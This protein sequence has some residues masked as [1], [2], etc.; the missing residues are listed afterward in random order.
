MPS[1][2]PLTPNPQP[3][4][5]DY[6]SAFKFEIVV[7][8][9]STG[10]RLGLLHT[11]HGTIETP[12]FMPV[13]TAGTVK[14][15]TQS[16][17]EWLGVQAIL[18]NTYHLYLRP[19]Q[20]LI[21]A[22]GGLHQFMSWPHPI[23]TDSGGFQVMSLKA[24]QRITEDGVEFRS[25]IDGSRH[26]FSPEKA[27]EVQL[28]FG[29]DILMI[30]DE[31]VSYPSSH[32][33]TRR[34]VKLTGRWA[35]RARKIYATSAEQVEQPGARALYGIVQGGVD[36]SLRRESA[37]EMREIGFEG[38]A[39][40]G[41]SVGEPKSLT[42]DL[43]EAVANHLPE[44]APRYLMG[45]GTPRDLAEGVARGID[46][47]DCVMPTRNARNACVFTSEGRLVIKAARYAR[48]QGPLD[49]A[50]RCAVCRR[51][52]R[53]YIRHLFVS[54]E[55]LAAILSTCHNLYFYLDTMNKIRQAIRAGSLR[56]FLSTLEG[57]I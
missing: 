26:F 29:S 42:Y 5:S 48:D 18:A 4:S 9:P 34:A 16:E 53:A 33:A 28:A 31:C 37:A 30:L 45:V 43:T 49:P 24:L 44:E 7:R 27:I 15:M 14:G 2:Q 25:H 38:Y 47:F 55:M 20:E 8:D 1:P 52:S 57:Q 3:L 41:L 12:V 10:A 23:L 32:E 22:A 39:I 19:G 56:G 35:S 40:G 36:F 51:Y 46:Q 13:G 6:R 17:L 50:C 21:K 11:A 54:G